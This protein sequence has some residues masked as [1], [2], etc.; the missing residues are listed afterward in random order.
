MAP[1][2]QR[3]GPASGAWSAQSAW[4]ASGER[5]WHDHKTRLEPRAA[6]G[7]LCRFVPAQPS[8]TSFS[9]AALSISASSSPLVASS[10]LM[11][12]PAS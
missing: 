3:Q 6:G 1:I 2:I 4:N 7:D 10:S 9:Y 5:G 8:A 12:Q 11:S